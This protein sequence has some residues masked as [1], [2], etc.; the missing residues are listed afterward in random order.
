[1]FANSPLFVSTLLLVLLV[2]LPGTA[3]AVEDLGAHRVGG[4]EE[5]QRVIDLRCTVC[6]TRERVD[7]AIK[8]RAALENLQKRMVGKGAVL[9][10]RDRKVLGTFWGSPLKERTTELPPHEIETLK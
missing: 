4:M 8:K 1:M 7:E 3:R 2:V 6:H 10:E 5:F 9:S